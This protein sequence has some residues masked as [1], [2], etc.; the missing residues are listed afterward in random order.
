[1]S[2]AIEEHVRR[3]RIAAETFEHDTVLHGGH[4]VVKKLNH[5]GEPVNEES[6]TR[7][8]S[9]LSNAREKSMRTSS[10]G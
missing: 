10:F 2:R 8:P 7:A 5:T 4:H 1:M 6:E 9:P 3:E